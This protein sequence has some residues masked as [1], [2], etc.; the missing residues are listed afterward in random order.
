MSTSAEDSEDELALHGPTPVA[1]L[2]S[3]TAEALELLAAAG[4]APA[5]RQIGDGLLLLDD[6]GDVPLTHGDDPGV[7]RTVGELALAVHAWFLHG[8]FHP[9]NVL[10][11][12]AG[13]RAVDPY[14]MIGDHAYD[15][16]SFACRCLEPPRTMGSLLDGYGSE[17]PRSGEWL[18]FCCLYVAFQAPFWN[19]LAAPGLRRFLELPD[20]WHR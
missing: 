8:D 7:R 10:I 12:D 15:L 11:S 2:A 17:P 3:S 16:A 9:D 6:L 5:T 1:R 13:L 20:G 19:E 18:E 4:I 14:G